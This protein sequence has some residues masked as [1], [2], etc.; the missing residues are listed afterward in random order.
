MLQSSSDS[1]TECSSKRKR[2][3]RKMSNKTQITKNKMDNS[4]NK[5]VPGSN[6]ERNDIGVEELLS[7]ENR[8]VATDISSQS[9]IHEC[10]DKNGNRGKDVDEISH[11]RINDEEIPFEKE[12]ILDEH[13]QPETVAPAQP[14]INQHSELEHEE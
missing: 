6:E 4:T 8:G 13:T 14:D 11:D 5:T 1:E 2:K 12:G 3:R 10:N 9:S 7:A